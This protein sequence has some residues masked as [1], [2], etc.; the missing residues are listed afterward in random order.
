MKRKQKASHLFFKGLKLAKQVIENKATHI[1]CI[2]WKLYLADEIDLYQ[3]C[4][5][6]ACGV[7]AGPA[8][9]CNKFELRNKDGKLQNSLSLNLDGVEL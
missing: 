9:G 3:D 5:F 4:S 8:L 1:W 6:D 2:R 7:K